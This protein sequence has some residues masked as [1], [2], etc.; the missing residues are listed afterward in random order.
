MLELTKKDI[1]VNLISKLVPL[2][3]RLVFD[4]HIYEFSSLNIRLAV[5]LLYMCAFQ[6]PVSLWGG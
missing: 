5:Q 4:G 6:C 2:R 3:S 1:M